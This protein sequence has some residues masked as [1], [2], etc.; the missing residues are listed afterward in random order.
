MTTA[1]YKT[2]G[3]VALVAILAVSTIAIALS[4][5]AVAA[6]ANKSAFGGQG[7]G[8][9]AGDGQWHTIV[10]GQ[11]KT[12]TPSDLLVTHNQECS[13]HTGL[14]L[15]LDNE[16]VTSAIR[17]DVRLKVTG[18]DDVVRYIN[19][20]PLGTEGN[21]TD[22]GDTA[23]TMCGRAYHI[24]TNILSTIFDL[25]EFTKMLNNGTVVCTEG[26]PIFNSYIRTK[27]AHGWS[28][29]V[30]N[31]G[32]G[33]ATIEVQSQLYDEL[34]GLKTSNEKGSKKASNTDPCDSGTACVDT[35]LEIG[36]RSLI[37]TEEKFSSG[38]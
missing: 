3:I 10:Q 33:I 20:M 15:D 12:S 27:S 5:S 22:A 2:F 32:S 31:L 35:I 36:K 34:D 18:A 7:V 38:I 16:D 17:Q 28:W 29:V 24:D 6:P 14:N 8:A 23:V 4:Q 37:I 13:I 30:P 11:I 21:S 26:D 25:C 19:P 9:I 1:K